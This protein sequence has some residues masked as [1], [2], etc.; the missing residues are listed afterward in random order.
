MAE[1]YKEAGAIVDRVRGGRGS[2]KQQVYQS[3]FVNKKVLLA[4]VAGTLRYAKI[5][6]LLLEEKKEV[7]RAHRSL[8]SGHLWTL[9][10][11]M[12]FSE[13][14]IK[15][16]GKLKRSLMAF[17]P[18]LVAM[19]NRMLKEK[20]ASSYE[21]LLP[22]EMQGQEQNP[23]YVRVN[24]IL[25]TVEAALEQFKEEGYSVMPHA[26]VHAKGK[27]EKGES[28]AQKEIS[29]DVDLDDVL[30]FPP[31]TD[32]H[33]HTLLR[34]G[35]IVLQDKA[36]C[37]PAYILSQCLREYYSLK[38]GESFPA[39]CHVIDACAAPGIVSGEETLKDFSLL[40]PFLFLGNKTSHMSA[41]MGGS[42][43]KIF[44]FDKEQ[45]RL[46]TLVENISRLQCR[47]IQAICEDFLLVDEKDPIYQNVVG[48]IA[49]PSC[50]GS[51]D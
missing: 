51:G 8:S 47:N 3:R 14:G 28:M 50:S 16:G 10:F 43:G 5:L 44:A 49:D 26:Q 42:D 23:R 4:L 12:L 9:V 11:D 37:L 17:H 36:S 29:R 48:V 7:A 24:T 18:Q 39:N 45:T 6:D 22:E 35:K 40:I 2:M 32:F 19:L 30:V 46:K 27:S 1:L 25:L 38:K 15:G 41:R 13:K 21:E 33:E 31:S 34:S 20:G